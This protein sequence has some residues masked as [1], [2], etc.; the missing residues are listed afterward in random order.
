M[1]IEVG[2]VV[3]HEISF[4]GYLEYVVS[5]NDNGMIRTIGPSLTTNLLVSTE[6]SLTLITSSLRPSLPTDSEPSGSTRLNLPALP[7]KINTPLL[8]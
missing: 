1:S 7:I 6:K 8:K 3:Q 5:I 2:D 4:D